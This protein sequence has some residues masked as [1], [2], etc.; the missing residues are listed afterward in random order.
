MTIDHMNIPSR[1]AALV[2]TLPRRG[3]PALYIGFWTGLAAVSAGYLTVSAL[4]QGLTS[5]TPSPQ[6]IAAVNAAAEAAKRAEENRR[7][8]DALADFQ[9]DVAHVRAE[10]E[11]KGASTETIGALSALEERASIETGK[12]VEKR[13]AFV[14]PAAPLV[15]APA[16]G[17]GA[18]ETGSIALPPPAKP[19][20]ATP[21]PHPA[22][23]AAAPVTTTAVAA[24]G[25][26]PTP[27]ITFG[28]PVVKPAPKPF[29]VQLGSGATLDQIRTA[30]TQLAEENSDALGA[31][32][33]RYS[34]TTTDA[35]GSTYDLFA[36]PFKSAVDARKVCKT[37][38]SRGV[39]C[40]V[41]AFGGD[42]L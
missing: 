5:A 42:A 1:E 18:F 10:L 2:A 23:A 3:L 36:G 33:P 4:D 39:D 29:G 21:S 16:A 11:Q 17:T 27:E 34:T 6:A 26:A 30:W 20:P 12:P 13:T 22:V 14:P 9:S 35:A 19:A 28:A 8:R 38:A 15:V 37:L 31:L 7:L 41:A 24:P 40:K 32:Q 25:A